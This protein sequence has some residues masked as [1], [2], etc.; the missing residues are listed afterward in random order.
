MR[1]QPLVARVLAVLQAEM[2]FPRVQV[3]L[4]LEVEKEAGELLEAVARE[5]QAGEFL[6]AVA[7][8]LGEFRLELVGFPVKTDCEFIIMHSLK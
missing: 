6:E 8:E 5:L 4:S 3:E 2:A 7:Q 1:V